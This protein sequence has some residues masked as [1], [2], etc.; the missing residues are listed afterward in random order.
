[1]RRWKGAEGGREGGLGRKVDLP[2]CFGTT[3]DLPEQRF[4]LA[5]HGSHRGLAAAKGFLPTEPTAFAELVSGAK[6]SQP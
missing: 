2:L 1:M 3:Y 5:N 4:A 6:Q